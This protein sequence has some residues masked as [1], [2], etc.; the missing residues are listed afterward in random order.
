MLQQV[1]HKGGL[2]V[3]ACA[4]LFGLYVP[5]AWVE[6]NIVFL[7]VLII[8]MGVPHGASDY[9]IFKELF[10]N[11]LKS[12]SNKATFAI[13]Y[14]AAMS[15]Y[16]LIWWVS[17][18]FAFSIF[19]FISVYHFGQSNWHY[20]NFP[21][22]IREWIS[23]LIWGGGILGVPI[24]LHDQEASL[25][26]FEITGYELDLSFAKAPGIFLLIGSNL[27]NMVVLLDRGE[28]KLNEFYKEVFNF[29][30][31]MLLFFTTPLLI[32]FGIY[33]VFW[34]SMASIKDQ[35]KIFN[36]LN[37]HFNTQKFLWQLV[38]LSVGAF[39]GLSI[40]YFFLGDKMDQGLNLGAFFLFI[41]VITVPH[42][43]L[44]DR[45]LSSNG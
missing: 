28:L 31:L 19:F 29:F 42:S 38:P 35:L 17:P 2:A 43:I 45:L 37:K 33:F 15:I 44:M 32:G 41:S 18:F 13:Y 8:L 30:I 14:L 22:K 4:I 26:I 24:L 34:H 7:A 5:K 39:I 9:L 23:Y 36:R 11:T 10:K 3:T 6:G 16:L 12:Q 20:V 1:L 27:I 25:I 40:L 21:N